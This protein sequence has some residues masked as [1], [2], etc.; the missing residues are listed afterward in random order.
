MLFFC[1]F[2][3]FFLVSIVLSVFRHHDTAEQINGVD[4]IYDYENKEYN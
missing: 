4:N 2:A 3:H 1:N